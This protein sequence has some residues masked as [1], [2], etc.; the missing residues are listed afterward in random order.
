MKTAVRLTEYTLTG[1]FLWLNVLLLLTLLHLDPSAGWL[2]GVQHLWQHGFARLGQL[3]GGHGVL[4]ALLASLALLVLFVTGLLLDLGAAL[5]FGAVEVATFHRLLRAPE[6]AWL[7]ALLARHRPYLGDAAAQFLAHPT[8]SWR[9]PRLVHRQ[10]RRY[11]RLR[12]FLL[13]Y[14]TVHGAQTRLD[15]LQDQHRLWRTSRALTFSLTLLAILLPLLTWRADHG[16]LS[17]PQADLLAPL[18]SLALFLLALAIL[19]LTF[20]RLCLTLLG[21][22]YHTHAPTDPPAHP[23]GSPREHA[24]HGANPARPPSAPITVSKRGEPPATSD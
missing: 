7:R 6:Q 24:S 22:V 9:D 11:E 10:R 2:T 4:E 16:P 8:L 17:T 3:S 18:L 21:Y 14:L 15:E 23:T 20:Q 13:T 1:G 5:F 19:R 12:T